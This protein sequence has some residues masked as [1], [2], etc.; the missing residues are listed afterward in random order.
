MDI[1]I[2]IGAAVFIVLFGAHLFGFDDII[3]K[4]IDA[5]VKVA[6]ENRR[7]AEANLEAARL[8]ASDP[9]RKSL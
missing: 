6:E 7:T 2:G 5:K 4:A 8:T 9:Y 1:A 3:K